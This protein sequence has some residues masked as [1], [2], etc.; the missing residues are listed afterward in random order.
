M[1]LLEVR[2]DDKPARYYIDGKRVSKEDYEYQITLA[3]IDNR[4]HQCFTTT[5][6]NDVRRNYSHIQDRRI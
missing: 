5:Y 3:R 4:Q 1:Q 6:K 2:R